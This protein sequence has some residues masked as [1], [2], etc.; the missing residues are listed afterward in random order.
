MPSWIGFQGG[1]KRDKAKQAAD[2]PPTLSMN[3]DAVTV[4][5]KAWPGG[6]DPEAQQWQHSIQ[7]AGPATEAM[8]ETPAHMD[9]ALRP[10]TRSPA[11]T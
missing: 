2:I 8:E 9:V 6:P 11:S 7:Y 3:G 10:E 4:A 1:R 5:L